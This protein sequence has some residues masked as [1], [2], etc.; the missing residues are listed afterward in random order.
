MHK[1]SAFLIRLLTTA[2]LAPAAE[3][4]APENGDDAPTPLAHEPAADMPAVHVDAPSVA[5]VSETTGPS[6]TPGEE[7]AILADRVAAQGRFVRRYVAGQERQQSLFGIGF[8]DR[9]RAHAI[10]QA[11]TAVGR[12]VPRIHRRQHAL[13]LMQGQHRTLGDHLE[14]HVGDHDRDLEYA[15]AVRIQPAHLHV[16]PHQIVLVVARVAPAVCVESV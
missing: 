9:R 10:D 1:A 16:E 3:P 14:L 11:R 6:E 7:A 8:A 2:A 15:I 4:P 5:P 13:R 12:G